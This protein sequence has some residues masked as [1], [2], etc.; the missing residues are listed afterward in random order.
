M[1]N[2][3]VEKDPIE[4]EVVETQ[5]DDMYNIVPKVEPMDTPPDPSGAD[6]LDEDHQFNQTY[7]EDQQGRSGTHKRRQR[8]NY[9][10][11]DFEDEEDLY[12]EDRSLGGSQSVVLTSQ[13]LAEWQD[14]VKMSDYL[15]NGRR[16]KFWEE[17]FTK[18]VMD[19]IKNKNLEMKK[20]AQ[21]LG[22][23][24]G[25]LYGRY[26]ETYGCLKHHRYEHW[27]N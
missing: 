5:S 11:D 13:E 10:E 8:Q 4:E 23:S 14:V 26:R 3:P 22:V 7:E 16:P 27:A 1:P 24:Y 15:K 6:L 20:A 21:L 9:R 2:E 25:T 18:R 17:H 19:A 12:A